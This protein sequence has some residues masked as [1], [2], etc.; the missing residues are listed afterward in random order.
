MPRP[1]MDSVKDSRKLTVR[2]NI[3]SGNWSS[4]FSGGL[5]EIN[6]LM[7]SASLNITF[8]EATGD[9]SADVIVA[10]SDGPI[11]FTYD[12]TTRTRAFENNRL[13]GYTG[14]IRREGN[15]YIERAFVFLPSAPEMNTPS[16][17]RRTGIQVMTLIL[18]H[19]FVH[20]C[21]LSDNDHSPDD[22]FNG[23]PTTNPGSRPDRDKVGIMGSNGYV[24]FPPYFLSNTTVGKIQ[25]I[26]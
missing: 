16:G 7:S 20:C 15:N 11:S 23:N 22:I 26:W 1:W 19:E 14:L 4:L 18:V 5:R 10:V 12:G 6:R 21:G 8:Q 17:T 25:S 24:W 9:S 3:G 2:N 13:H